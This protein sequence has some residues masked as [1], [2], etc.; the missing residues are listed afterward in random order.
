[1]LQVSPNVGDKVSQQI[2]S[3][4]GE[5]DKVKHVLLEEPG[6]F[7]G[8]DGLPPAS[9]G[10]TPAPRQQEFKKPPSASNHSQ[11]SQHRNHSNNHNNH[12]AAP[13]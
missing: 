5:Y 2:Q 9:P 4:L 1:M 10:P 13:R 12:H 7:L 11:H 6:R 3:K 8:S